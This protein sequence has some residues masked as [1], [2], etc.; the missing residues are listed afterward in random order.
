MLHSSF[1]GC[2]S[3][4]RADCGTENTTLAATHM[5][6]RHKHQDEFSGNKSFRFGSSTTNTVGFLF[7]YV[8]HL[9]L[10]FVTED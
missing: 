5:S 3:I 2:P 9:V 4:V 1:L 10:S 8:F 6:L 7:I